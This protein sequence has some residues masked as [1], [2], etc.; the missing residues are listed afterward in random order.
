MFEDFGRFKKLESPT[1]NKTIQIIAVLMLAVLVS[2]NTEIEKAKKISAS[3]LK[4][5][6]IVVATP[7]QKFANELVPVAPSHWKNGQRFIVANNKINLIFPT[8][9]VLPE[10]GDTI[11]FVGF[12]A[13]KTVVG[14]EATDV[15]FISTKNPLDTMAYRVNSSV[16]EL[17]QRKSLSIPF[18]VDMSLVDNISENLLGKEFYILTTLWYDRTGNPFTGM[19]YVPVRISRVVAAND[20][21]PARVFFVDEMNRESSVLLT[22]GQNRMGNRA[23]DAQ[24]SFTDPRK[25]YPN[26]SDENWEAI[27]RSKVRP[28]MTRDEVR[29]SLGAPKEIDRGHSYSS[30]YERWMYPDGS[31]LIFEDG[32]LKSFRL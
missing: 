19:R 24:F 13:A 12:D 2:C 21:Y 30:S 29:L 4:K 32:L 7:E 5:E 22:V 6:K 15:K 17:K 23:F 8:S 31:Y 14:T 26:I 28:E 1:M 10:V 11:Q 20:I 25:R 9:V 18:L 27:K 3:D 16:A